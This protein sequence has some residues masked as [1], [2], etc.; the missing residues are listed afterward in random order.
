MH[1]LSKF[2]EYEAAAPEPNNSATVETL[3]FIIDQEVNQ[4]YWTPA[5]PFFFPSYFL[6]N[7]PSYQLGILSSLTNFSAAFS[8]KISNKIVDET[9]PGRLKEAA[10][11]LNDN[12]KTWL[13]STE[14]KLTS[15]SASDFR[16]A[17][18]QYL[19]YDNE[20]AK[21]SEIF[22]KNPEDL[23]FFVTEISKSLNQSQIE[24]E[25]QIRE[26]NSSFID[27]KADNIFYYHQGRMYAYLL[28]LKGLGRDYKDIIVEHNLYH[29]WVK[30]LKA[31]EDGVK[32][33]PLTVRNAAL[34]SS[35]A[36]NHLDYLAF[37]CLKA[38]KAM[39]TISLKLGDKQL[40]EEKTN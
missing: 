35:I 27:F 32:L 23:A 31:L 11:F 19:K 5:L 1:A 13:F 20:L 39:Q 24:L 2:T 38:Q 26:E 6:D 10:Q 15:S 37:D 7:M 33:S 34:N 40:D 12:G 30:T 8:K 9:S 22:Y 4:N 36:P 17:R 29:S 18:K 14:K 3:A 16:R 25:K 21:G 28:I